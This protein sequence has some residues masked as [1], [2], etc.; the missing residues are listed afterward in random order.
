MPAGRGFQYK[1]RSWAENQSLAALD[2]DIFND[3]VWDKCLDGA[4]MRSGSPL[5]LIHI[6]ISLAV[7]PKGECLIGLDWC[8]FFYSKGMGAFTEQSKSEMWHPRHISIILPLRERPLFMQGGGAKISVELFSGIKWHYLGG[9]IQRFWVPWVPFMGDQKHLGAF[10]A[11]PPP[12]ISRPTGGVFKGTTGDWQC[13]FP[14][15]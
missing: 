5:I 7:G 15:P 14:S 9:G 8:S 6:Q 12:I 3:Q 4:W 13:I 2:L 1:C 11:L 10:C